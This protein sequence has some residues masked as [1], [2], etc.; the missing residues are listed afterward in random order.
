M[1]TDWKDALAALGATL[2]PGDP[3][4][5]KTPA[6]ESPEKKAKRTRLKIDVEKKGRGGKTATIIYGFDGH[7]DDQVADVA[8]RLKQRLGIGGSS[9]GGEILLQGEVRAKAA[10]ALRELG[11][12]VK[13]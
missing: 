6:P 5:E 8:R 11:Y 10:A 13:G 1:S 4:P 9:R 2:P 12:D 7:D 3:E